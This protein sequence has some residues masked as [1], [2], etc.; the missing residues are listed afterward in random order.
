[1]GFA[2][3]RGSLRVRKCLELLDTPVLRRREV[4]IYKG[5]SVQR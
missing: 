5:T 4:R 3:G 2:S 1:M